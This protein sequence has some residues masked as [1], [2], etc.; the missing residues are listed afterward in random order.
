MLY[1]VEL[2]LEL[3]N[4]DRVRGRTPAAYHCVLSI[5]TVGNAAWVQPEVNSLRAVSM[6][7]PH[8]YV[9]TVR[10]EG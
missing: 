1:A 8:A 3:E 6:C 10:I 7:L 9:G 4:R 5:S 2:E